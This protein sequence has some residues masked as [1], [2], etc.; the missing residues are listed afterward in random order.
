LESNLETKKQSPKLIQNLT[1]SRL[2]IDRSLCSA[3]SVDQVV[4]RC[5]AAVL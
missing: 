4:D 3:R 5:W 1:V 2:A